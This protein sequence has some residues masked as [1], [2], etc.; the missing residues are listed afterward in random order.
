MYGIMT[1]LHGGTVQCCIGRIVFLRK[2]KHVILIAARIKTT[3]PIPHQTWN[4][5]G[6]T[7]AMFG[8]DQVTGG[9]QTIR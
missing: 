7:Y 9:V 2:T 1:V 3:K 8:Y 5:G 4:T 6:C